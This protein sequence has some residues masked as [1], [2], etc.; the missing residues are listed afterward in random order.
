MLFEFSQKDILRNVILAPAWYRLKVD[1]V[2]YKQAANGQSTNIRVELVA[3]KN[4][5]TGVTENIEGV[6]FSVFYNSLAI[7]MA[8]PFVEALTGE[9][10][11]PGMRIDIDAAKGQEIEGFVEPKLVE[12]RQMNTVSNKWR[13]AS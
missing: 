6:P 7:G 9:P 5:E 12:G 8:I 2:T 4:A 1:D 11:K 13:R 3:L 10:V